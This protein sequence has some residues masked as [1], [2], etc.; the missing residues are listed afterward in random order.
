MNVA[1]VGEHT[2]CI[3]KLTKGAKKSGYGYVT[4]CDNK[5]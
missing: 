1:D 2:N 3:G 5:P 4:P